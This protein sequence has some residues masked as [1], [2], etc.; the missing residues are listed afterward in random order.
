MLSMNDYIHYNEVKIKH[1][2]EEV[3]S[4]ST[5]IILY[6]MRDHIGFHWL[7]ARRK[8]FVNAV[9]RCSIVN[10]KGVNNAVKK[11]S[12]VNQKG[13]IAIDYVQRLRPSGSQWT[14]LNCI[15]NALLALNWRYATYGVE[16]YNCCNL[17]LWQKCWYNKV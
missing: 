2:Q 9:Q 17:D 6:I 10:Q 4:L 8:I 1:F 5:L 13:I 7:R 14:S 12:I 11:C 15:V 16:F 3:P